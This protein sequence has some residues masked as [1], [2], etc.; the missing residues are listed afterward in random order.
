MNAAAFHQA[1]AEERYWHF[2][3]LRVEKIM[4]NNIATPYFLEDV[5]NNIAAARRKAMAALDGSNSA[6]MPDNWKEV[7]DKIER[8]AYDDVRNAARRKFPYSN[9]PTPPKPY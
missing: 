9:W 7:A 5:A 4:A 6:P 2:V 3:R 8:R 1:A